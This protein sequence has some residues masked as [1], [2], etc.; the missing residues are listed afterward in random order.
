[1]SEI[2]LYLFTAVVVFLVGVGVGGAI[3]DAINKHH[4]RLTT[5]LNAEYERKQALNQLFTY[6]N[7]RNNG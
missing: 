1:M 5:R 4:D 3:N 2:Q 6:M 7:R